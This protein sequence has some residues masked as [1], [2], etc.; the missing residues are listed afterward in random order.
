MFVGIFRELAAFLEKVARSRAS[1]PAIDGGIGIV[2]AE[3]GNRGNCVFVA[4]I[5]NPA[6]DASKARRNYFVPK[7]QIT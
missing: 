7:T 4:H 5:V 6:T 2:I 1:R 3:D